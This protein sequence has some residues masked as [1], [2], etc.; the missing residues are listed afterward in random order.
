MVKKD[1]SWDFMFY[2]FYDQF[3]HTNKSNLL[4]V[5][6]N[7]R[8]FKRF[9]LF[10]NLEGIKM[11]HKSYKNRTAFERSTSV[12][13]R[14]LK[15]YDLIVKACIFQRKFVVNCYCLYMCELIIKNLKLKIA[16]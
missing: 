5:H 8:A 6:R 3:T 9:F 14:A 15:C 10:C 13:Y 4:K 7:L 1:L 12:F 16:T 2:I 11:R